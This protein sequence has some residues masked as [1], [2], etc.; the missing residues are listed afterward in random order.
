MTFKSVATEWLPFPEG[1]LVHLWFESYPGGYDAINA[2]LNNG[3]ETESLWSFAKFSDLDP[4]YKKWRIIIRCRYKCQYFS[5][6][7]SIATILPLLFFIRSSPYSW[8]SRSIPE[9]ISDPWTAHRIHFPISIRAFYPAEDSTRNIFTPATAQ[10]FHR[11]LLF[12]FCLYNHRFI[13]WIS[14]YS[15]F[16]YLTY[17]SKIWAATGFVYFRSV[18][19]VDRN[20]DTGTFFPEIRVSFIRN[21]LRNTDGARLE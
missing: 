5:G 12:R 20:P 1:Q 21:L 7:G 9:T 19:G 13:V 10:I 18:R 3:S 14:F 4:S 6:F 16:I 17:I 11:P 15:L 2:L 8:R